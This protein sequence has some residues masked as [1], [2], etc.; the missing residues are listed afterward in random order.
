MRDI[1]EVVLP[2]I[3]MVVLVYA[4]LPELYFEKIAITILGMLQIN[5]AYPVDYELSL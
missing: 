3:N 4:L 5:N 2:N 1:Y